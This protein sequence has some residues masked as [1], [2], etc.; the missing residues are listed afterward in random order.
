MATKTKAIE[1]RQMTIEMARG[2]RWVFEFETREEFEAGRR[3][4]IA[5]AGREIAAL[6][7]LSDDAGDADIYRALL[8]VSPGDETWTQRLSAAVAS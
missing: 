7:A 1:F 2:R 5:L 3:A 6:S 8:T 4:Q